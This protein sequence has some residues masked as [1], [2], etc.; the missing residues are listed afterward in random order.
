MPVKVML[1]R[2]LLATA[3]AAPLQAFAIDVDEFHLYGI[4][5]AG[6]AFD[7]TTYAEVGVGDP[8]TK[9]G[10]TNNFVTWVKGNEPALVNPSRVCTADQGPGRCFRW[11]SMYPVGRCTVWL[12]PSYKIACE[13][14]GL[15]L[16][17]VTYEGEKLDAKRVGKVPDAQALYKSFLRRYRG[18]GGLGAAYRCKE[19]CSDSVPGVLIFLWLG[20]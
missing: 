5:K 13:K 8:M 16:S 19:G 11:E 9:R 10:Y 14:G 18:A 2:A 1:L 3:L 4:N 7:I 6:I 12:A 15:P 17:G 20:D